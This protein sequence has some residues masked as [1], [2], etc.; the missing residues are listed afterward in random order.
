MRP[1]HAHR[2]AAASC[3]RR[4][5]RGFSQHMGEREGLAQARRESTVACTDTSRPRRR[6]VEDDDLGVQGGCARTPRRC[7]RG[8]RAGRDRGACRAARLRGCCRRAACALRSVETV[9]IT[10]GSRSDRPDLP[11]R[12]QRRPRILIGVCRLRRTARRAAGD[13][14][15]I[16]RPSNQIS[17]RSAGRNAMMVLP[18]VGCR[19]RIAHQPDSAPAGRT[20]CSTRADRPDAPVEQA[21][22][23]NAPASHAPSRSRTSYGFA[24]RMVTAHPMPGTELVDQQARLRGTAWQ[25]ARNLRPAKVEDQRARRSARE[26]KAW[27]ES[28]WRCRL[29]VRQGRQLCSSCRDGPELQ[30]S[31]R[32]ARTQTSCPAYMT[33]TASQSS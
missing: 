20:R 17:R 16:C 6:L 5:G 3:A 23:R 33:L 25:P 30:R 32:P 19:I 4:Q 29:R 11:A 27:R 2:D 12:I 26:A 21:L 28:R 8:F 31:G 13:N 14:R 22:R 7:C 24:M 15:S 18:S 9:W 1:G 10:S